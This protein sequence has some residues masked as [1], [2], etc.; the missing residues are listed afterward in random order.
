MCW[1]GTVAAVLSLLWALLGAMRSVF[2]TRRVR[3]TRDREHADRRIVNTGIAFMNGEIA[4]VNTPIGHREQ[5]GR[6]TA[7]G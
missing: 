3:V 4:I 1:A 2:R 7:R 6:V 5:G